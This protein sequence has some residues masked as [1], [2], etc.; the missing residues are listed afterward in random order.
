MTLPFTQ[1]IDSRLDELTKGSEEILLKA[2]R[3]AL[4]G[5]GKRLRPQLVLTAVETLGGKLS[6]AIDP[7]CAI[8]MV[9]AYSLIHDDLPCMDND[10]FRRGRPTLHRAFPEGIA[11]LAGDALLSEAF[12]VISLSN[13]LSDRQIV[14]LTTLLA[15]RIGKA[16]MVG[17]QAI[18]ILS[19]GKSIA[20]ELLIE[21]DQKKTGDLFSCSLEFG[22]IIANA[23]ASIE[24]HL[25]QAGLHLGLAYQIRDDLDDAASAGASQK[26][27]KPTLTSLLG[28]EPTRNFLRQTF[29]KIDHHLSFLPSGAPLIK[30][31]IN[32]YLNKHS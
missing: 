22:A 27:H 3:Y 2:M 29:E 25:R 5:G 8:E 19:E 15:N 4:L 16:G 14:R 21:M 13:N 26:N 28:L 7:A 32:P 24:E 9:H 17:G 18:D 20:L 11:V 31:L 23:P 12:R 1:I 30:S 10:D 6:D